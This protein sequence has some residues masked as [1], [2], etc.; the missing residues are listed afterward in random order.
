MRQDQITNAINV[1]AQMQLLLGNEAV[2]RQLASLKS[3]GVDAASLKLRRD[4]EQRAHMIDHYL[5]YR[6]FVIECD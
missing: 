5:A 6:L 3:R 1:F 4:A 2:A